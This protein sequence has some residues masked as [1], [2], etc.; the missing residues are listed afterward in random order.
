MG[1]PATSAR[2]DEAAKVGTGLAEGEVA[3]ERVAMEAAI[4]SEGAWVATGAAMG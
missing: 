1:V 3:A 2:P 4:W